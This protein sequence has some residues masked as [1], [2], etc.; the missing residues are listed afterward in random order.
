MVDLTD[1]AACA[2]YFNCVRFAGA[3]SESCHCIQGTSLNCG[4]RNPETAHAAIGGRPTAPSAERW[5]IAILALPMAAIDVRAQGP[6]KDADEK[7]RQAAERAR[8]LCY[9]RPKCA[10][11]Q[12]RCEQ[13]K[14]SRRFIRIEDAIRTQLEYRSAPRRYRSVSAAR[15]RPRVEPDRMMES[16]DRRRNRT[17]RSERTARLSGLDPHCAGLGFATRALP[18][19]A[20]VPH[21]QLR[22][23][24]TISA[25]GGLAR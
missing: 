19:C 24:S 5:R 15:T 23:A 6:V 2:G 13:V 21:S 14:R 25:C 7:M 22:A 10:L 11:R 17:L 16:D 9:L 3:Y 12:W 1:R 20:A 18:P 4:R 8:K